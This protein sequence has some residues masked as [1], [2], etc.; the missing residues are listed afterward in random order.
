[1]PDTSS[2][3][4]RQRLGEAAAAALA[5]D[6]DGPALA[7]DDAPPAA[8]EAGRPRPEQPTLAGCPFDGE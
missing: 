4:A 8:L 3:A 1:M 2:G 5:D 7:L 6:D